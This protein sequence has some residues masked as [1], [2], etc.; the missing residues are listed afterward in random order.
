MKRISIGVAL[1]IIFVLAVTTMVQA[2]DG[3]SIQLE[4]IWMD[5]YGYDEHV[6][7][8]ASYRE[9]FSVDADEN[10]TSDYSTTYEPINLN[11]K[12]KFPLRAE[13][14]YKKGQWS[15]G[16][17]GWLFSTDASAS[18][19]VTTPESESTDTGYIYY[20]NAVRMWDHT[21]WPLYNELETSY[22]SPVDYWA[23][24]NLEIWTGDLFL[25]RTLAE[26]KDSSGNLCLGVKI[27]SLKTKE[28]LGQKQ[29][30]FIYDYDYGYTFDNHS[31]LESTTQANGGFM[32]GPFLGF[33]GEVQCEK[34]GIQGSINQSVLYGRVEHTGF[35]KDI[36]DI[37]WI[38]PATD[39]TV[40]HD[41]YTGE[42]FFSKEEK[43]ALAVTELKLQLLYRVTKRISFSCGAFYS[44]WWNAPVAPKWSVPGDW[45]A[46]EGTG[47]RLEERT[48][49]FGGL[50]LGLR[51][52][53]Q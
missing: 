10:Y 2:Q 18:G 11:M 32:A 44:I 3:W 22:S 40:W 41:V 7:D 52:C 1:S 23:E 19:T 16:A 51:F 31:T 8:I 28:K 29:R 17:S 24:D 36:D 42:F 39:E 45:E 12:E 48:L 6:G 30:A 5:V 34:F 46:G 50:I 9:E 26:K 47:W 35:W 27:G 4:P 43:V 37:L 21:L 49:K 20:E 15:L 53:F 25:S 38:D 33:Q 13:L 14:T